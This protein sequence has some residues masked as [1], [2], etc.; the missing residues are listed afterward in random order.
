MTPECAEALR[1]LWEATPEGGFLFP[2]GIGAGAFERDRKRAGV[3][4]LDARGR[5]ADFHALRYT[6]CSLLARTQPIEG[7]SKLMRHGS[8]TLTTQIYLDLGLDRIGEGEWILP[9][10]L[11]R[12][13]EG[14]AA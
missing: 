8:L 6:F 13:K 5:R 7:V 10:L 1:A 12:E 4:K 3:P 14:K 2:R 11:P 9:P